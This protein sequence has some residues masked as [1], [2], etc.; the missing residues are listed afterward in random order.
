MLDAIP[1]AW[2]RVQ[3]SREQGWRGETIPLEDL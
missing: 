3:E 1:G 2:E